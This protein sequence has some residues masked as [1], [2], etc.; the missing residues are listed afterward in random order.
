M[1]G[2]TVPGSPK[3]T[4]VSTAWDIQSGR[5]DL[6]RYPNTA[7][8][9]KSNSSVWVCAQRSRIL[10]FAGPHSVPKYE[11][12]DFKPCQKA[13]E[14]FPQR[15]GCNLEKSVGKSG[16]KQPLTYWKEALGGPGAK[17]HGETV[18]K[19]TCPECPPKLD[20]DVFSAT[21]CQSNGA[22]FCLQIHIWK[23]R[24]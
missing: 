4:Y 21:Y 7:P 8:K 18:Y 23:M 13:M 10:G 5:G 2:K 14:W 15:K 19:S 20:F 11:H 17:F 24:G 12:S 3:P 22:T 16:P 6:S 1:L 9:D